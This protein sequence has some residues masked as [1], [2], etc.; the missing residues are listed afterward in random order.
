MFRG[1]MDANSAWPFKV[2]EYKLNLSF[3]SEDQPRSKRNEFQ[4]CFLCLRARRRYRIA[5]MA[6]SYLRPLVLILVLL[7]AAP[8]TA[9]GSA[10]AE[11]IAPETTETNV[12]DVAESESTL[13]SRG[14]EQ[15]L[16][17]PETSAQCHTLGTDGLRS[18]VLEF[19]EEFAPEKVDLLDHFLDKYHGRE[20]VL[21]SNLEVKYGARPQFDLDACTASPD[22]SWFSVRNPPVRYAKY[23]WQRLA[24]WELA[25]DVMHH[26][27][28]AYAYFTDTSDAGASTVE[29]VIAGVVALAVVVGGIICQVKRRRNRKKQE[30]AANAEAERKEAAALEADKRLEAEIKALQEKNAELEQAAR[31]A[32]AAVDVLKSKSVCTALSAP[33]SSLV[34]G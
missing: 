13:D 16:E 4:T 1:W 26:T 10:E 21:F 27:R 5:A 8:S 33:M 15:E 3:S 20:E 18:A 25:D 28:T 23:L 17:S 7:L 12:A 24:L 19:Y 34:S 9:L 22:T 11:E 30:E 2:L 6:F 14:P 29:L 32:A 31:A